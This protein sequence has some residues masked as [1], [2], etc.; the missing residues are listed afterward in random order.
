MWFVRLIIYDTAKIKGFTHQAAVQVLFP[1]ESF[2][3]CLHLQKVW[4]NK[5]CLPSKGFCLSLSPFNDVRWE[6][7]HFRIFCVQSSTI[8]DN[9]QVHRC[10]IVHLI[11]LF[12]LTNM[13]KVHSL[14]L[15][16]NV[17]ALL[18]IKSAAPQRGTWKN[19]VNLKLF[20]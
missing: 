15:F 8:S 13:V 4:S 20:F 12:D 2:H 9:D 1:V 18:M 16:A 19:I 6:S 17:V 11:S 10:T 7:K 14:I 3:F 5:K